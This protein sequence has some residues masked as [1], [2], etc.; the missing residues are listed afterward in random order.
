MWGDA[1]AS[2][3]ISGRF[4]KSGP[5]AGF[6]VPARGRRRRL[7]PLTK[8]ARVWGNHMAIPRRLDRPTSR[9]IPSKPAA[10]I[11]GLKRGASAPQNGSVGRPGSHMRVAG[12]E[13][14]GKECCCS[15]RRPPPVQQ[16][17]TQASHRRRRRPPVARCCGG[18]S[19]LR[20]AAT[21]VPAAPWPGERFSRMDSDR[22]KQRDARTRERRA[23]HAVC[24]AASTLF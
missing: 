15:L 5:A 1:V 18:A 19:T 23:Q 17:P 8:H 13:P 22:S 20:H 16:Q 9:I 3:G 24:C 12:Q 21:S 6:L 10:N 11:N 4:T 14:A 7:G 2:V